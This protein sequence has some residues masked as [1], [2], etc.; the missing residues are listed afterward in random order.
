MDRAEYR[1]DIANTAEG[2]VTDASI[3]PFD[4]TY[5]LDLREAESAEI[6]RISDNTVRS[7]NWAEYTLLFSRN[8]AACDEIA[9]SMPTS[10]SDAITHIAFH[11]YR[12]DLIAAVSEYSDEEIA[13][14]RGWHPCPE[15]DAWHETEDDAA[16]CCDDEPDDD[17]DDD[18]ASEDASEDDADDD[19]GLACWED[20]EV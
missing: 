2:I 16:G 12:A 17:D 19:R 9:D 1:Q 14:I 15:C 11:A 13:K 18:D 20:G 6:D 5:G 4:L 8:V 7:G 3:E 10:A